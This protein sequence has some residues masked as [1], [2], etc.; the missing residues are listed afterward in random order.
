MKKWAPKGPP[1]LLLLLF[2]ATRCFFAR[3]VRRGFLTTR[4]RF[5]AGLFATMTFGG[6]VRRLDGLRR[7]PTL[8]VDLVH[9]AALAVQDFGFGRVRRLVL[10]V[11]RL[12]G[13]GAR[14]KRDRRSCQYEVLQ[15]V[16]HLSPAPSGQRVGCCANRG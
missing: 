10:R 9:R 12:L 3:A 11:R 8:R 15:N 14:C 13:P 16:F 6:L 1:E 4:R 2:V 5:V 7:R